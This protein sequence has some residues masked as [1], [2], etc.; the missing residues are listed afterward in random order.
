M[1]DLDYSCSPN[2]GHNFVKSLFA[3]VFTALRD[4]QKGE[5]LTVSYMS[6]LTMPASERREA[7]RAYGFRCFCASCVNS[8]SSDIRR[9]AIAEDHLSAQIM[10]DFCLWLCTPDSGSGLDQYYSD[11]QSGPLPL[12]RERLDLIEEEGI[13]AYA[14]PYLMMAFSIYM[15]LGDEANSI[16]C[17]QKL[18]AA[19]V[20][21]EG[22]GHQSIWMELNRDTEILTFLK[23]QPMWCAR[24]LGSPTYDAARTLLNDFWEK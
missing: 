19:L 16:T 2:T 17:S 21:K 12:V 15:A 4:I 23:R 13:H 11:H 14:F 20:A 9:Q 5:Q 1:I 22:A 3:M 24:S 8:P 7:L 6:P 18:R 10:H